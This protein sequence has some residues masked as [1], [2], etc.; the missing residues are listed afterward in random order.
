MIG[1]AVVQTLLQVLVMLLIYT[2]LAYMLTVFVYFSE[3]GVYKPCEGKF[4]T[5]LSFSLMFGLISDLGVVS[6]NDD[7]ATLLTTFM[8][9]TV[10]NVLFD[11]VYLFVLKIVVGQVLGA[12]I[13][14]KFAQ[15]R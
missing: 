8:D 13:I 12:I 2:I 9:D 11:F 4:Y 3:P 14:D 6:Y 10:I 1:S 15:I 7:P 5:C